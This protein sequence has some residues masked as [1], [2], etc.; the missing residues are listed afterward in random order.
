MVTKYE[1]VSAEIESRSASYAER[2]IL[3]VEGK[4]TQSKNRSVILAYINGMSKIY[5]LETYNGIRSAS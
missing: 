3:A 5:S 1:K 2:I 4:N